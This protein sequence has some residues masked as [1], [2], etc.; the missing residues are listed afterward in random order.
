MCSLLVGAT[1][2][3]LV[4]PKSCTLSLSEMLSVR[5]GTSRCLSASRLNVQ[6][7]DSLSM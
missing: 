2:K 5:D 4:L 1:Q 3:Q 7:K 6:D